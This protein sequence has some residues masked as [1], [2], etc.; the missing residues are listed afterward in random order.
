M[1]KYTRREFAALSTLASLGFLMPSGC[2]KENQEDPPNYS[3][4]I[5]IGTGFGG[6]VTAYRLGLAGIQTTVLER[7]K[8]WPIDPGGDTFSGNY[9]TDKRSTWLK[10]E[11]AN[12]LPFNSQFDKYTGVL[13]RVDFQN[14]NVY[15]GAAAVPKKFGYN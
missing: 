14:I 4:A 10:T 7:G 1:K 11:S 2:K 15:A 12:P 5:V 6:A 13:E 3:Q 8:R 9:P